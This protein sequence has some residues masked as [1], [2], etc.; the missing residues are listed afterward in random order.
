[1]SFEIADGGGDQVKHRI[2][3]L[4]NSAQISHNQAMI[5]VMKKRMTMPGDATDR[6]ASHG[7]KGL[8][9]IANADRFHNE[10]GNQGCQ[11]SDKWGGDTG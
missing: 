10:K 5:R 6:H 2:I 3:R 8:F 7:L 1:M 11:Q 4:A 9:K